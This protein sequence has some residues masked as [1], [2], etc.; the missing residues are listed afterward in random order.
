MTLYDVSS[1]N[2]PLFLTG[3]FRL[4]LKQD[5]IRIVHVFNVGAIW[6]ALFSWSPGPISSDKTCGL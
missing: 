6:L 4:M 3:F 2:I 1:P 5:E